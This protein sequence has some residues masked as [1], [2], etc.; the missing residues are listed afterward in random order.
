MK[1]GIYIAY[2]PMKNF[3]LKQEG[4]GRYLSYIVKSFVNNKH[5][6]VIACPKWVVNAIEELFEEENIDQSRVELLVS[7]AEPIMIK[8][9]LKYL[10]RKG[11]KRK[12]KKSI[13][14]I[15]AI[16]KVDKIFDF[17]L[18]MKNDFVLMCLIFLT[19]LIGV[20]FLPFLLLLSIFTL[21]IKAI[22]KLFH[23]EV[24]A[25]G[26]K[27]VFSYIKNRNFIFRSLYSHLEQRYLTENKI[28]YKIRED[29]AN[30]IIRKIKNMKEP[31]DIWYSPMAFWPEFN[32]IQGNRVVCAPDL[33]TAEYAT[34]FSYLK[35]VKNGT[36]EVRKTIQGGQFFITYCEYLKNTLV[37]NQFGKNEDNVIAIPHAINDMRESLEIS[38]GNKILIDAKNIQ[39]QFSRMILQTIANNI[40]NEK[41]YISSGRKMFAFQDVEYIFYASQIRGNKNI[42]N[43]IKAYE[44]LLRKKFITIKL[45]LTCNIN[46]FPEIKEYIYENRLQYD[47]LCFHSVTSQ[48]LGALYSCAKLVVNPTLYEGGFPFTFG[49]GMSVGTPSVMSKIPQVMEV[50]EGYELEKYF[51]DPYNYLDMAAKIE[52]GLFH[53]DELYENEK[54][55]F[56]DLNKRTW[57]DV[58]EEYV[59]AFEY[60]IERSKAGA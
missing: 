20:I 22:N 49:E 60:F 51:F 33:V 42:F 21:L 43:L 6:V 25:I 37:V 9:Y 35:G 31:A 54:I 18:L 39:N 8:R 41:D 29:V 24:K 5:Q 32:K 27:K 46:I 59:K 15:V 56:D 44:Y 14:K 10:E 55:L 50:V 38:G 40:I 19:I 12:V 28:L 30:D 13:F 7:E 3:S 11:K 57:T 48:Q 2:H 34:N 45:F 47:I 4:L 58:G 53:L 26:I 36:D 1:I 52:Y 17:I 23:F 16:K